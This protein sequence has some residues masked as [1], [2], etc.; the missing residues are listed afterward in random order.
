MVLDGFGWFQR[1]NDMIISLFV[2]VSCW[3]IGLLGA[4]PWTRRLVRGITSTSSRSP[5]MKHTVI[6][7]RFQRLVL[8]NFLRPWY[9][10]TEELRS[11]ETAR[12]INP[13]K[14]TLSIRATRTVQN[15]RISGLRMLFNLLVHY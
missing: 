5:Q 4:N 13:T 15:F 6:I 9:I 12:L 11:S 10:S 2:G 3:Q 7:A 8:K 14:M 1:N